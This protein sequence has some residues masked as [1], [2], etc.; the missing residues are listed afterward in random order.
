MRLI[1]K[2]Y[3]L[4]LK[5]K[6]ELDLLLC[7]LL[8][9]MGF[10]TDNKPETGNRQYGVDIRAHNPNEILL[11]VVKQGNLTRQTWSSGPNAVRQSLEEI[12]DVYLGF[13]KG[14]DRKKKIRIVVATNGMIDE[15]VRPQW[16]GYTSNNSNV[17]G[18][19]VQIEFWNIDLIT[20]LLQKHLLD[21]HAF[22]AEMQSMLRRA[23]YFVEERDYRPE[24]YEQI[25]DHYMD[26]LNVDNT[27]ARKKTLTSVHLAS[28]MIAQYSADAGVYKISVMV[29]EYLIIRYWKHMMKHDMLGD[30]LHRE[31]LHKY[32]KSYEKWSDAYYM[33]VRCCCDGATPLP[34][35]NSVEKRVIL[36]EILGYLA[37]YTYYLSYI[38]VFDLSA[39]NKCS[40]ITDSIIRLLNNHTEFHYAPYDRHIGIISMLYRLLDRLGRTNDVHALIQM[41]CHRVAYNYQDFK[42]YPTPTDD[43]EDAV[44]IDMGMPAE[45]YVTTAFWG[46]MLEWMVLYE[47]Q[48]L[49]DSL[50]SFLAEDLK[51]VTK[52]VW[53]LRSD[54][55][56]HLY[57]P[58]V[59][60]KAGEGVVIDLPSSFEELKKV[61][62]F[63]MKQ[64]KKDVFSY[65]T[66]SFDALEFIAARYFNALVRVKKEPHI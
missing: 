42:K 64:Y 2:D 29:S 43:F 9:Q 32:L 49:Y 36:Y 56:E 58:F 24:F 18:M 41:Q 4:Q 16:D 53:F 63:I 37:S 20:D 44:N 51:D 39:R 66:Y 30:P 31:W 62:N 19:N 23:L 13:L 46:V 60:F 34:P 47:Q 52:C 50:H 3:L 8:L 25:I 59:M 10:I 11:F 45:E 33:S 65:E 48:T 12:N 7:D 28:Q 57:E 40:Q 1:I 5:E 26:T 21:E 54:E 38:G 14:N 22:N 15:A 61:V 55:E 17:Q 27:K 6:D 35:C